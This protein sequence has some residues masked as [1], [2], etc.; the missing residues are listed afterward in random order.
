MVKTSC[1]NHALS[2]NEGMSYGGRIVALLLVMITAGCSTV[3]RQPPSEVT[4]VPEQD[5]AVAP[6]LPPKSIP[7]PVPAPAPKPAAPTNHF[8]LNETW[9][10]LERWSQASGFGT[11]RRIATDTALVYS[12]APTNGGM[13]IKIGSQSAWWGGL[14]YRLGFAP[15]MIDG[16]PYVHS[17]D[18]RKNFIPLLEAPIHSGTNRTL[19]ID[20]GH[21]G[22]D[23]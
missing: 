10:S 5:L 6:A 2:H 12:F 17:L 3:P 14:E 1:V 13:A 4:V 23:V 9:I 20:P 15:Q 11:P 21:G 8:N 22:T 7:A 18:V 16:H 19:V